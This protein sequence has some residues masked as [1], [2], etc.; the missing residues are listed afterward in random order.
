[1]SRPEFKTQAGEHT[2]YGL[3]CGYFDRV[4]RGGVAVTLW[5][6]HGIFHVRAHDF[7]S[8]VR[9]LW[10]SFEKLA[11]ARKAFRRHVRTYTKE[12]QS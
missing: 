8:S 7:N 11:E 9:L 4:E 6:E 1:M 2:M 3:S 5:S 10:E 12:S